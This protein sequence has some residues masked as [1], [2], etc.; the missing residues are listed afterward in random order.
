MAQAGHNSS[1]TDKERRA[2]RMHHIKAVAAENAKVKAA[3]DDRKKVKGLA[4]ADG[5]KMSE[6]DAGVRLME[7]EDTDIFMS[8]IAELYGIAQDFGVIPAAQMDFFEDRR[9]LVD[10]AK[11][12]GLAAGLQGKDPVSP[13][14]SGSAED[15]AW[16]AAWH[17]GQEEMRTQ[18]Q[19]AMEK[20]NA[21]KEAE[22][23]VIKGD[24]P[25]GDD[26]DEGDDE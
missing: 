2:L 24:M 10:R 18:L 20:R 1:L 3:N 22:V 6:I 12:E 23:E 14:G 7:M 8:E 9:P 16:M 4:K 11:D 17:E 13:Y 21:A 25:E 26:A 5:F 15:Q 19:S